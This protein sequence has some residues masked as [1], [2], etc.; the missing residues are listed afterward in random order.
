MS[1]E[2][3]V[4]PSSSRNAGNST[5][6]EPESAVDNNKS[7]ENVLFVGNLSYFCEEKHLY[8][9]FDQCAHVSE[10]RIMLNDTRTRSLMFGFVTVATAHEACEMARIFNGTFFLGRKLRVALRHVRQ[11]AAT[12]TKV[13]NS[14]EEQTPTSSGFS[15][16]VSF[17]SHFAKGNFLFIKPTE[18]WLRKQFMQFGVV[19]D[20]CVKDYQNNKESS[21]QTGYGFIVFESLEVAL[22]VA[23][24]VQSV[25]WQ[26]INVSCNMQH[27]LGVPNSIDGS[28]TRA[29][30][31]S[32]APHPQV[33]NFMVPKISASASS[34]IAVN[35]WFPMDRGFGETFVPIPIVGQFGY[36]PVMVSSYGHVEYPYRYPM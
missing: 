12:R 29:K 26:G 21:N 31:I 11:G 14:C 5:C 28:V 18:L 33:R 36:H 30:L 15:V 25:E 27:H 34:S 7:T 20:C 6:D 19:L 13:P 3:D 32:K 4:L 16:Q 23:S 35:Q 2:P 9:L 1:T 24:V 22:N 10:V 17:S 8:E